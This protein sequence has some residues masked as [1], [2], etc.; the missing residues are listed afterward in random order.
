MIYPQ[1]IKAKKTNKIVKIMIAISFIIGV[2][3]W[4]IN[5]LTTPD[6]HWTAI[7]NSGIIYIWVTV[8]YAVRRNINIAGHVLV[9]LIA[10][11]LLTVYIDYT[12][13]FRGWAINIAIPIMIMVANITMLVLTIVSHKKY[14]RY[15][16]Y[17]LV[18]VLFSM[19]PILLITEQLVENKLLSVISIAISIVNFILCLS[20]CANDVKE[21]IVRKFH[22]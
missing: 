3:L 11:T 2:L 17:Q 19:L 16:I 22:L 6:I 20:L 4:I 15:A 5:K 14:I 18:I 21:A 13:G 12:L 7:A 1:K 8:N 10:L 9:Q